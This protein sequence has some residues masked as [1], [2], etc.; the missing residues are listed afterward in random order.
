MT[1]RLEGKVA[2]VTGAGNGIGRACALRF[3]EEGAAV[4]VA[5][6]LDEQ[7]EA[8]AAAIEE[9]GG[10]ATFVHLDASV[11]RPTTRS[12]PRRPPRRTGASTSS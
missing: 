3:A 9:A 6:L 1:G 10:R 5:D 12:S 7:G 2:V 11:A 4:V 8:A